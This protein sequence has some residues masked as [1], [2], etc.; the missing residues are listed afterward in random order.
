MPAAFMGLI[1]NHLNCKRPSPL[2][3]FADLLWWEFANS[4]HVI[5]VPPKRSLLFPGNSEFP[6]KAEKNYH[7]D[8]M[9]H[10]Q[11]QWETVKCF[12]CNVKL[13]ADIRQWNLKSKLNEKF[14]HIDCFEAQTKIEFF[15]QPSVQQSITL[16]ARTIRQ[17]WK[18]WLLLFPWVQ[19]ITCVP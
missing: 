4:W 6:C 2:V 12:S 3:D 17:T 19:A 11:R 16:N 5:I 9:D 15:C 7:T 18:T 8:C 14:I 1:W 10:V 13:G